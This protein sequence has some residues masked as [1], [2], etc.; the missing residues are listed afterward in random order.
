MLEVYWNNSFKGF[1]PIAY[2]LKHAFK[3]R[4]VRFHT[5]PES[6]RYPEN[7][8]EYQEIISRHNKILS[9][10]TK[11]NN[12][13]YMV[14]VEYSDSLVPPGKGK[15]TKGILDNPVYW[16]AVPMHEPG[17][18]EEFHSY[19]HLYYE[20]S[21]WNAGQLDTL[22]RLVADEEISNFMVVSEALDWVFH[23]YDGGVDLIL[24]NESEMEKLRSRF[25]D[26]LSSHSSGM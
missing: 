17:E 4:W 12:E 24:K 13:V 7:E 10:V 18:A 26:W 3:D 5:L 23:P 11:S 15:N 2:E 6:K 8:E 19:F 16:V 22:F 9:E 1:P 25:E 21:N 14:G 20:K